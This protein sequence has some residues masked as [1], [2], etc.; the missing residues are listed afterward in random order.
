MIGLCELPGVGP[1]PE[2]QVLLIAELFSSPVSGILVHQ[3]NKT[4]TGMLC[5]VGLTEKARANTHR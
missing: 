4:N 1:R 5:E 2:G 3:W